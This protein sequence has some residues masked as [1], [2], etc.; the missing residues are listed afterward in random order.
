MLVDYYLTNPNATEAAIR[1]GYSP[2]TAHTTGS[3]ILK[4]PLVQK[5]LAN[6]LD[7]TRIANRDEVLAYLTS[8]MRGEIESEVVVVVGCG[9]G[10]SEPR[11]VMK[12][13]DE[14]ERLKASEL[15]GKRYGLFKDVVDVSGAIPVVISGEEDIE[16]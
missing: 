9:E 12:K 16:D 2:K 1:A 4:N 14:R 15:L 8:V 11:V 10:I 5:Y 3:R 13:P 6:N 7:N